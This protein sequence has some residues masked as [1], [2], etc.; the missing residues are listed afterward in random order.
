MTMTSSPGS[1][2]ARTSALIVTG[3]LATIGSFGLSFAVMTDCT[4]NYNCTSTGCA[5]CSTANAVLTTS[6]VLQG[7]LLAVAVALWLPPVV[8]RL[9]RPMLVTLA[10][11]LALV[12]V[13]AFAAAYW[14][15]D[16]TY[17]RPGQDPGDRENYC[18][19]R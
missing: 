10:W 11:L 8:R 9:R 6:W 18:D 2:P 3:F 15:A 7:L 5:P 16:R 12:S 17:C 19:V 14:G 1:V 4:N 13:L